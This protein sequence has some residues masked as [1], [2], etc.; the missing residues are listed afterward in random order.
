MFRKH[1]ALGDK[2]KEVR[3]A[4]KKTLVFLNVMNW[5]NSNGGAPKI[6]SQWGCG[7]KNHHRR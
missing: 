3:E 4:S 1:V 7:G 5:E 6:R 2:K